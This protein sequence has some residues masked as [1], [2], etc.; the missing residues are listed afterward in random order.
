VVAM[1]QAKRKSDEPGDVLRRVRK[2]V[3]GVAGQVKSG[4]IEATRGVKQEVLDVSR[5]VADTVNQEAERVFDEQRDRA[6]AK[7]SRVSKVA[8]QT[9]H[10]LHAVRM[11]AVA[12]VVDAAAERVDSASKYIKQRDLGEVMDDASEVVNRHRALA[13]GGLFLAGFAAA[14][15][16]KATAERDEADDQDEL[17]DERGDDDDR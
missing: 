9:A 11:D 12:D 13:V 6:A 1:R 14:R 15:F 10:A 17:D 4:A 8:R 2:Q 5:A 7:V 3:K 16:L